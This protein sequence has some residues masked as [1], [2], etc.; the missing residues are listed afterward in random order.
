MRPSV[1]VQ[2]RSAGSH[3]ESAVGGEI[4]H[5]RSDDPLANLLVISRRRRHF[6]NPRSVGG[7]WLKSERDAGEEPGRAQ[8]SNDWFRSI[9]E[10]N[11]GRSARPVRGPTEG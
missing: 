11:D 7:T 1:G 6:V 2:F 8:A 3:R 5:L 9:S 10:A 4:A